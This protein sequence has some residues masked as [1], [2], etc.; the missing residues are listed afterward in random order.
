VRGDS[1]QDLFAKSL[2]LAGLGLVGATGALIDYWP[3]PT[4]LPQVAAINIRRTTPLVQTLVDLRGLDLE[5]PARAV[6]PA[7]IAARA[8]QPAPGY[9]PERAATRFFPDE[10]LDDTLRV[11]SNAEPRVAARLPMV[12]IA[13][14]STLPAVSLPADVASL[15]DAVPGSPLDEARG[16]PAVQP[17]NWRPM[18]PPAVAADRAD[19]GFF[20]GMLKKTGSSVSTSI[21]KASNSLVGAVRAVGG[22]VKKAF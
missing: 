13:L 9:A 18:T 8:E 19:D 2:A 17:G 21:G 7:M 15:L 20:S 1:R 12:Q 5:T 14:A 3:G 10:W 6:P 16:G 22:A 11:S 4:Q